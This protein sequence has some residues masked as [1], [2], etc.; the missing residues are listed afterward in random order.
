LPISQNKPKIY[1]YFPLKVKSIAQTQSTTDTKCEI[2]DN[3]LD[4]IALEAPL[5]E[6]LSFRTSI[7]NIFLII[8]DLRNEKY[9]LLASV[10]ID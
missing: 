10:A 5:L 1:C 8:S 7:E 2:M 4:D 6:F 3:Q 9:Q